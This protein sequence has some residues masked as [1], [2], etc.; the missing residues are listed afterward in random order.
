[1]V[2]IAI[3]AKASAKKPYSIGLP[4]IAVWKRWLR[5]GKP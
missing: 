2:S 4:V 5:P 1:M 3:G